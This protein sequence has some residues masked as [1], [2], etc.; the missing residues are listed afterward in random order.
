MPVRLR[1]RET[2][3]DGFTSAVLLS[4]SI[5]HPTHLLEN[6]LIAHTEYAGSC[7]Q[8]LPSRLLLYVPLL[9]SVFPNLMEASRREKEEALIYFLRDSELSDQGAVC[10]QAHQI[11]RRPETK[12]KHTE[13]PFKIHLR[14][15]RAVCLC[16]FVDWPS[17]VV[18]PCATQFQ[19]SLQTFFFAVDFYNYY[20]PTLFTSLGEMSK[21]KD[22][23]FPTTVH[24]ISSFFLVLLS[25]GEKPHSYYHGNN[26][27]FFPPEDLLKHFYS[28]DL[29]MSQWKGWLWHPCASFVYLSLSQSLLF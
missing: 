12:S 8:T 18:P 22:C 7:A 3:T 4:Q 20:Y 15:G 24:L 2:T 26:K 9:R 28:E 13:V 17:S 25:A 1:G 14:N 5:S 19:Q 23:G 21:L 11:L 29:F 10:L 27:I 6:H 16:V